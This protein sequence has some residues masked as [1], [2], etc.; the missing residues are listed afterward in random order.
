MT[1]IGRDRMSIEKLK[2][3]MMVYPT[4]NHS[5]LYMS[6]MVPSDGYMFTKA[7]T[8]KED[9][10]LQVYDDWGEIPDPRYECGRWTQD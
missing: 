4:F 10:T 7:L 3:A 6:A 9:S 2:R 1:Y 8:C 5:S